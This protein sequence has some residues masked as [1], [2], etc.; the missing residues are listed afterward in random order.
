LPISAN[1]KFEPILAAVREELAKHEISFKQVSD[2]GKTVRGLATG[3][4]SWED[5]QAM[6]PK[7]EQKGDT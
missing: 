1:V 7:F 4:M 2:L 3:R 6:F 5:A